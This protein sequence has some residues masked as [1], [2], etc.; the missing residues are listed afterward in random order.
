MAT[1]YLEGIV[2]R[3]TFWSPKSQCVNDPENEIAAVAFFAKNDAAL[4]K[5]NTL[6][7]VT[8]WQDSGENGC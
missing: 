5:S 8:E 2:G 4:T 1:P 7:S 6:A 3:T